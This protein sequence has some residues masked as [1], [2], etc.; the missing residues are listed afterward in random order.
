MN[1]ESA[2]VTNDQYIVSGS[3]TGELWCWDLVTS[4]VVKKFVHTNGKVLNSIS[5][6]PKKDIMLTS[7]V[8]TIKV[9]GVSGDV[10]IESE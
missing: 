5:I 9:W 7:S 2:I 8:Q 4:D 3:V 10:K 6:H 1:I